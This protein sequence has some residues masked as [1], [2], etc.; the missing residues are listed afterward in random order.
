[1]T[2]PGR[3]GVTGSVPR[4]W[5]A[6]VARLFAWFA[7]LWR[8]LSQTRSLRLHRLF[9]FAA[10]TR[11]RPP[12]RGDAR[13]R[14]TEHLLSV[15]AAVNMRA[16]GQD[17]L[18]RELARLDPAEAERLRHL[19][20]TLTAHWTRPEVGRRLVRRRRELDVP[21]TIRQNL[22]RYAGRVLS[23]VY[24]QPHVW[25]PVARRPARLLLIGD[26]SHSM[27]GYVGVALYFFHCLHRHF[28]I[29]AWIFSSGVTHATPWLDPAMPF[30]DQLRRLAAAA[31]SWGQGTRLGQ[32]LEHIA[33]AAP[34]TAQTYVVIMTDGEIMLHEGERERIDRWMRV[35]AARAARVTV[36]TPNAEL[37][38]RGREYTALIDRVH[39]IPIHQVYEWN[40][41][42]QLRAARYGT[43][44]RHVSELALAA[45]IGDL[46]RFCE[47]VAAA[48]GISPTPA[49]HPAPGR[50]SE[51][52]TPPAHV[53]PQSSLIRL[54]RQSSEP[55]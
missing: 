14:A 29:D 32:A 11:L 50:A 43:L 46:C 51:I 52:A 7:W 16:T 39:D 45:T 13:A 1:M 15:T 21:R 27:T 8:Q 35:L 12:Q 22:P 17:L 30:A 25:L 38:D 28:D 4:R 53:S 19:A 36:L 9:G 37:A 44:A 24:R 41:R 18:Y 34:V 23:F 31:G 48:A 40:P 2:T 26:V 49:P 54:S 6:A 3:A 42:W 55:L 10:A 20:A 47:G 5:R 33:A